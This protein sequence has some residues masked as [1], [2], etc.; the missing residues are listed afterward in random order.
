M[1]A[2]MEPHLCAR[3]RNMT[4]LACCR[5]VMLLND[6]NRLPL[7]DEKL[8][9]FA[10]SVSNLS[11]S[12]FGQLDP[13]AIEALGNESQLISAYTTPIYL[14][15][16]SEVPE[17]H[18]TFLFGIVLLISLAV[19]CTMVILKLTKPKFS[20]VPQ[21]F[22]A[23][24][25]GSPIDYDMMMFLPRS[26]RR[27]SVLLFLRGI[28]C[29]SQQNER[30]RQTSL[31][32]VSNASLGVLPSYRAATCSTN[33]PASLPPPPYEELQRLTDNNNNVT[34]R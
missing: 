22:H 13:G 3:Q 21:T 17:D 12:I 31:S 2:T 11:T 5:F 16:P 29:R 34:R 20:G 33:S 24:S 19:C 15:F 25:Y 14:N 27:S 1:A 32:V 10:Q 9:T 26:Q 7:C 28:T 6:T 4:Q 18:V 8:M 30:S 23:T